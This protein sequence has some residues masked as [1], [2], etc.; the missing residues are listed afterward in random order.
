[1]TD[2]PR[3][4]VDGECA[5]SRASGGVGPGVARVTYVGQVGGDGGP[6]GGGGDHTAHSEPGSAGA[7]G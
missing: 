6:T 1:M 4:L 2:V 5:R 7:I 3:G